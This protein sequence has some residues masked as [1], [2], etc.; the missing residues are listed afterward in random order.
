MKGLVYITENTPTECAWMIAVKFDQLTDMDTKELAIKIIE[1]NNGIDR[2]GCFSKPEDSIHDFICP[3]QLLFIPTVEYWHNEETAEQVAELRRAY[4]W[5]FFR[6][7]RE[8]QERGVDIHSHVLSHNAVNY[9]NESQKKELQRKGYPNST[10]AINAFDK[11]FGITIGAPSGV[12]NNQSINFSKTYKSISSAMENLNE[13]F[14]TSGINDLF[15]KRNVIITNI[16]DGK[17]VNLPTHGAIN[18]LQN[19]ELLR[20]KSSEFKI[21][22]NENEISPKNL[23]ALEEMDRDIIHKQKALRKLIIEFENMS[24]DEIKNATKTLFTKAVN[25]GAE[26][27]A[28]SAFKE[29]K[30]LSLF[31]FEHPKIL[32]TL[33]TFTKAVGRTAPW[34]AAGVGIWNV[35]EAYREGKN[36]HEEFFAQ[37]VSIGATIGIGT[38]VVLAIPAELPL[39]AVV[40]IAVGIGCILSLLGNKI[41][42]WSKEFY[43]KYHIGEHLSS[44]FK[45]YIDIQGKVDIGR[46]LYGEKTGKWVVPAKF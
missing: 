32:N 4:P 30:G 44:F 20:E 15:Q 17:Q 14:R 31:C 24:K 45:E 22:K 36:W 37:T 26:K 3:D 19:G 42:E 46:A 10:N 7:I 8:A 43:E 41:Y 27:L 39:L 40:G 21:L 6:A 12:L 1:L 9:H 34:I 16:L 28:E 5:T 11:T 29:A 35:Y 25:P 23:S 13:K 18:R 38:L 33:S 2:M